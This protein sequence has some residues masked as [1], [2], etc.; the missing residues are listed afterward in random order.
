MRISTWLRLAGGALAPFWLGHTAAIVL[1]P[2]R[3]SEEQVVYAVMKQYSFDALGIQRTH[4]DFYRGYG[5][6]MSVT[7]LLFIIWLWQLA[8]IAQPYPAVARPL[9]V[10]TAVGLLAFAG[11]NAFW[12]MMPPAICCALAGLLVL[13]GI[14][15]QD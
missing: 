6:F 15:R 4:W 11:V 8:R 14:A 1:S 10:S 9:L 3:G 2:S 7:V 12:F 13:A 5:V